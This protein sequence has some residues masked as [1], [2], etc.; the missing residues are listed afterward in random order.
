MI[1]TVLIPAL[2]LVALF[3]IAKGL[4]LFFRSREWAVALSLVLLDF[5]VG[6]LGLL[7]ASIPAGSGWRWDEQ[8]LGLVKDAILTGVAYGLLYLCIHRWWNR[9]KSSAAGKSE[10]MESRQQP[11]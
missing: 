1:G 11:E 10:E 5:L 6:V 3:G 8:L 9:S 2:S 7:L 4:Y